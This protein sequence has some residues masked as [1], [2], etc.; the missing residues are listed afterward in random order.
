[1]KLHMVIYIRTYTIKLFE[2][3][4]VCLQEHHSAALPDHHPGEEIPQSPDV[5][6][7]PAES[8]RSRQSQVRGALENV[9]KN[10]LSC[11][12]FGA[13][14]NRRFPSLHS[15]TELEKDIGNLRSGLKSVE[16]VSHKHL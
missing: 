13:K 16:S 12:C 9:L 3:A 4:S 6:G 7:G 5:P 11:L 1:M 10:S 8:L 2:R 15:M 14:L